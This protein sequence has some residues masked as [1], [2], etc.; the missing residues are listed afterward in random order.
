MLLLLLLLL[1]FMHDTTRLVLLHT[2]DPPTSY[3]HSCAI[4]SCLDVYHDDDELTTATE[5]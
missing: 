1:L 2:H 5:L 4:Y 3:A